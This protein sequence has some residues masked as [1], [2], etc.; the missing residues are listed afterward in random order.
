MWKILLKNLFSKCF[1]WE[2]LRWSYFM[3]IIYAYPSNNGTINGLDFHQPLII[4]FKGHKVKSLYHTLMYLDLLSIPY[5]IYLVP[6]SL[7]I[8]VNTE[9]PNKGMILQCSSKNC[10]YTSSSI[11]SVGNSSLSSIRPGLNRLLSSL[12]S[13]CLSVLQGTSTRTWKYQ[14]LWVK[15]YCTCMCIQY[16]SI[17]ELRPCAS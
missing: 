5:N 1:I 6:G 3:T 13:T 17:S 4:T 11:C 7:K 16:T 15:M 10:S 12:I 2:K 9:R 14:L 8:S